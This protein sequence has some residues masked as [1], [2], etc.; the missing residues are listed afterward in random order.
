M[1][2][3]DFSPDDLIYEHEDVFTT[4]GQ[5]KN[6]IAN[7]G[8]HWPFTEDTR[9]SIFGIFGKLRPMGKFPRAVNL[10]ETTVDKFCRATEQQFFD[11]AP[12]L[13]GWW[14]KSNN[15]RTG[16]WDRICRPGPGSPSLKDAVQGVKRPCVVQQYVRLRAGTQQ[17]Y[18]SWVNEK[19]A[20]SVAQTG[21]QTMLWMGALHSSLAI[22]YHAAPSWDGLLD[23]APAL[24]QPDKAWGAVSENSALYAWEGSKYLERK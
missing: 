18:L 23:L 19:V 2:M 6:Y 17:D 24:P 5:T 14:I 22:V 12:R 13:D 4:A 16:G 3:K 10:W 20:P 8:S 1:N 21:W 7:Q 9:F 15:Q 11:A